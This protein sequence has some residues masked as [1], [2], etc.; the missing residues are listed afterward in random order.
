MC[1]LSGKEVEVLTPSAD[2]EGDPTRLVRAVQQPALLEHPST[3]PQ[4]RPPQIDKIDCGHLQRLRQLVSQARLR[5]QVQRLSG[6]DRDI[7]V[8]GRAVPAGRAGAEQ[9]GEPDT[10]R[11]EHPIHGGRAH[12]RRAY[13]PTL[14][15]SPARPNGPSTLGRAERSRALAVAVR[16]DCEGVVAAARG[17]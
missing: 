16:D 13:A 11:G 5:K 8:A 2:L 9:V 3:Q 10:R 15:V 17:K 7:G 6:H 14:T 4:R 12:R 1:P